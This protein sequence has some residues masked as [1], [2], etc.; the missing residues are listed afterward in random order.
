[1]HERRHPKVEQ[2]IKAFTEKGWWGEVTLSDLFKQ[3]VTA[4]PDRLALVDQPTA[5]HLMVINP[6]AGPGQR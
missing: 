3:A 6:S 4:H 2:R 5:T 1:M